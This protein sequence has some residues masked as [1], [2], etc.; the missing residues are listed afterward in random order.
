MDIA[1][2]IS[3]RAALVTTKYKL[4]K[5]ASCTPVYIRDR[6]VFSSE[7]APH[8]DRRVTFKKKK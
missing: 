3:G 5:Y 8:R 6:P 2:T 4:N 1:V 7:R